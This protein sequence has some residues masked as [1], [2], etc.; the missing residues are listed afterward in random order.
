MGQEL[1]P[2]PREIQATPE[3]V[4]GGAPLGRIDLGVWQ[5]PAAQEASNFVRIDLVIFGLA[6]VDGLHREGMA[7]DEG[8]P[9]LGAEVGQPGPR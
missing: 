3:E 5:H 7:Q 2:F 9:L 4:P 6:A 1:G 8:N